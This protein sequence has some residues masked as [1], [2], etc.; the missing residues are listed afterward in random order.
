MSNGNS[1]PDVQIRRPKSEIRKKPEIRNS[2]ADAAREFRA[3]IFGFLSDLGFRPSDL[4]TIEFVSLRLRLSPSQLRNRLI[5]RGVERI[6][7]F[8]RFITHVGDA[9]GR[10][11]N[12]S[13]AAINEEALV[14]HE[15]LELRHIDGATAGPRSI[16][17][18]GEGHGLKAGL[19]EQIES[20]LGRPTAGGLGQPLMALE[21]RAQSFGEEIVQLR[22]KR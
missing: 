21:T 19:R 14:F 6:H 13:V 2:N 11:L 5:H 10:A 20:M 8:V 3:S 16:A 18:A 17:H 12:F 15:F 1:G 9:E 7:R 4:L 22:G